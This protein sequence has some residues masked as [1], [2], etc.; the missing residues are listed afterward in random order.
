M[1]APSKAKTIKEYFA[2][3]PTERK[4]DMEFLHK[5]IQKNAPKLKPEFAYNMPGYGMF[6]YRNY[7]HE[8]ILWP[9]VSLASQKNY[10]SLY[11][12]ALDDKQYV[13]EKYKDKLGKVSVGKSCIRFKKVSDLNLPELAKVL[14]F[15]QKNPGFGTF[16]TKKTKK[17]K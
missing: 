15:A 12:C 8:P 7:K 14:K 1:F 5:F 10:M 4:K 6:P 16:E 13:A 3:V 17:K 2:M 11:V 9:V